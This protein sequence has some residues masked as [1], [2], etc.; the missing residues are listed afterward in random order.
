M[1]SD[2]V[3]IAKQQEKIEFLAKENSSLRESLNEVKEQLEWLKRQIFGKRSEKVVKQAS[4]AELY[5]AGF[6]PQEIVEQE[7]S[8]QLD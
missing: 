7:K 1:T 8:G 6:E 3:L 4:Q 5:L 2:A